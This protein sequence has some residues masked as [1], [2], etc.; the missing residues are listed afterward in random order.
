[1]R[2]PRRSLSRDFE[3]ESLAERQLENDRARTKRF[4][5]LLARKLTRMSASPLALLR[6]SAPLFYELL[7]ENPELADGPEG[8]GWLG[9]DMHL[10]N[11]GAYRPDPRNDEGGKKK[12]NDAVFDLNDFDDAVIGP[13]RLDVLRLSTSLLLAGREL[14]ADGR[15]ALD[16][17]DR[18]LTAWARAA[19]DEARLPP[20]PRP[21]RALVAQVGSRSRMALVD[22]RTEVSHGRRRFVR[23]ARYAELPKPVASSVASALAAYASCLPI[24]DQPHG[25]LRI[26]D[27]ALRIAGTGS[28]G[29]LRI[30]VLV[31]DVKP[32][33]Y[34]IF[35]MK[36]QGAPSA[37]PLVRAPR[38]LSP[39]ERVVT[40]FRSCV[41]RPPRMLGTT[42]ILGT[43]MIVRKLTPQE[44]KLTYKELARED[45]PGLATYLGA[46]LGAAHARGATKP[47]RSAWSRA[48]LGYLRANAIRLA[49]VHEAIYLALCDRIRGLLTDG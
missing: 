25:E 8:T 26:V 17:T 22:A 14:G 40:G 6:G 34:S 43:S 36:E 33:S 5:F 38:K 29:S 49:G 24:E 9:G 35:D 13:W 31:E 45:L 42:K 28:L 20:R 12:K 15:L 11:F 41:A 2:R 1:V 30:G 21:V 16:L 4:P 32:G 44:D 27:A 47:P 23:G 18:L 19:F 46:L 10:E 37:T 39:A 48:D 7:A 3:A